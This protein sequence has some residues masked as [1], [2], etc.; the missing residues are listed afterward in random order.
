MFL[1]EESGIDHYKVAMGSRPGHED[2]MKGQ[3][4]VEDC[5]EFHTDVNMLNGQAYYVTVQVSQS[6]S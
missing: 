1:D 2:I 5:G 3:M 4:V 6:S